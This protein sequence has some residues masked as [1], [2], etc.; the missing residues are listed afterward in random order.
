MTPLYSELLTIAYSPESPISNPDAAVSAIRT[1]AIPDLPEQLRKDMRD[2]CASIIL[3]EKPDGMEFSKD[4]FWRHFQQ[5]FIWHRAWMGTPDQK[6]RAAEWLK[7][8]RETA[9]RRG[10]AWPPKPLPFRKKVAMPMPN[11]GKDERPGRVPRNGKNETFNI[12]K[13]T[14]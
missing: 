11:D 1:A 4:C 7:S 2:K 13:K 6:H 10:T 8:Q 14:I 5:R 12:F 9:L 3:P